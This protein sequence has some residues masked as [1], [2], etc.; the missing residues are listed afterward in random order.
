V[1]IDNVGRRC[2]A[3]IIDKAVFQ[4]GTGSEALDNVGDRRR[5]ANS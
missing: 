1:T 2:A 5:S 4:T 3:G